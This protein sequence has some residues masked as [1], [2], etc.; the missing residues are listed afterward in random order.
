MDESMDMMGGI[1]SMGSPE[2]AAAFKAFKEADPNTLNQEILGASM[3]AEPAKV[4]AMIAA[5]QSLGMTPEEV[6]S[7]IM[8]VDAL[9]QDPQKYAENRS[10]L[11][12]GG[13][14]ERLFP[15][16]FDYQYLTSLRIALQALQRPMPMAQGFAKGGIAELK[17]IARAMANMGRGGDSQL[18]HVNPTE[19][20]MLKRMGGVGTRNP[21]TGLREYGFFKSIGKAI[22][23]V[24]KAV[25]N[26]VSGVADAVKDFASS[27]VGKIVTTVALGMLLGPAAV[28]ILGASAPAWAVAGLSGAM[29]GAG[30][31]LLGGGS[32]KDALK[33]G[34]T[35]GIMAGVGTGVFQGF[36]AAYTGPKTY[37]EMF[38]TTPAGPAPVDVTGGSIPE[39]AP[40]P[41]DFTFGPDG[42]LLVNPASQ[43]QP[44]STPLDT[45]SAT[46][47]VMT[48]GTVSAQ[49]GAEVFPVSGGP[50]AQPLSFDVEG[51]LIPT[52]Y[53]INQSLPTAPAPM[54]PADYGL[55]GPGGT[56]QGFR[57][58]TPQVE[59]NLGYGRNYFTGEAGPMGTGVAPG[60]QAPGAAT[61]TT[62]LGTAQPGY[63]ETIGN[64]LGQGDFTGAAKTTWGQISPGQIA[65]RGR[66]VAEKAYA[67]TLART[68][69]QQLAMKAYEAATP[70]MLATYGPITAAG[71][72]I[73]ALSG[74][75]KAPPPPEPTLNKGPTG[76]DL[77]YADPT[78]YA[79]NIYAGQT[80]V[81]YR[82]AN[83]A[84]YAQRQYA[85]YNPFAYAP[86]SGGGLMFAAKGGIADLEKFPR[87][88]GPINGPGTGTSD[89][90]PAMLSDGEFVFTAKAVRGLGNGSR[91]KGAKKMYKMM[92]LLEKRAGGE[93]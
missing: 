17:P 49:G 40:G 72:G 78:K 21:Y 88:T 91:R 12:A 8:A 3:E 63:F 53:A 47:N 71:T 92:K 35:S 11:I 64:Q 48:P 86:Q 38:G 67:D 37:G 15:E 5:V 70:G 60:F 79:P 43:I 26:A 16:Q 41:T 29:A 4:Q 74:A 36:D 65:E 75:F 6:D 62:A 57:L 14:D 76:V 28:S 50:T 33:A 22:S 27:S 19:M 56:G 9:L 77:Y 69:S 58:G 20:A 80:P 44:V 93:V 32:L 18:V 83:P 89:S 84:Y 59:G 51:N 39:V 25:G 52:D 13:A 1:G 10:E 7:L 82:S 81:S 54:G 68:G 30:A 73:A 2:Q 66:V 24:G 85:Y 61:G 31:T 90:I 34:L 23:N 45:V 55:A 46:Q 42:E 87:K